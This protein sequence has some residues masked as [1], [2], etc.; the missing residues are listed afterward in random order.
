MSEPRRSLKQL[1]V[2]I[3]GGVRLLER[4][5]VRE[6]FPVAV[7]LPQQGQEDVVPEEL[8]RPAGGRLPENQSGD[9]LAGPR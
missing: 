4:A 1:I 2:L 9:H 8:H 5:P 3:A 6:V 7:R